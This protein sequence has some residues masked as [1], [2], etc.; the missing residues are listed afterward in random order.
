MKK[1]HPCCRGHAGSFSTPPH[2]VAQLSNLLYRGF[3]TRRRFDSVAVAPRNPG[4]KDGTL[5]GF[6][7][8]QMRFMSQINA[9][10]A[11]GVDGGGISVHFRL[12][13]FCPPL[14]IKHLQK[15][16]LCRF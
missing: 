9:N 15:P 10:K 7:E 4:L 6:S 12:G 13:Y 16:F 8:V 1:H 3:P 11:V 2:F 14:I 5:L